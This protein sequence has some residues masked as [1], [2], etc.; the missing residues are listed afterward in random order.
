MPR[1]LTRCMRTSNG[2]P[3]VS[4]GAA[5]SP[6]T[7]WVTIRQKHEGWEEHGELLNARGHHVSQTGLGTA[8]TL[9][10]PRARTT[11]TRSNAVTAWIARRSNVLSAGRKHA[12]RDLQAWH[13]NGPASCRGANPRTTGC[14]CAC[15][16]R[17]TAKC[18]SSACSCRRRSDRL[19]RDGRRVAARPGATLERRAHEGSCDLWRL[20]YGHRPTLHNNTCTGRDLRYAAGVERAHD[21]HSIRSLEV[22]CPIPRAR[23]PSSTRSAPRPICA[24]AREGPAP[25]RRRAAPRDD[26]CGLGDR[27]PSRRRARRG[28]ADGRP[29]LRVRHAATTA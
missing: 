28:R 26:R 8:L 14:T 11:G 17:A 9:A 7:R 2:T 18:A 16:R 20:R 22:R 4:G 6:A 13:R 15:A 25:G 10:A 24:P 29:A 5:L 3:P 21:P 1:A 23:R 19:A 12:R 27:R